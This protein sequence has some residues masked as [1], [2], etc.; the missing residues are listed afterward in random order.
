VPIA[1]VLRDGWGNPIIFVPASGLKE[2]R[3][4]D[5]AGTYVIRSN[6][7]YPYGATPTLASVEA[8]LP[9]SA[10]PFFASAGPD[11][12]FQKGD[13]NVYSFQP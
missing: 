2:V 1:P 13:D 9:P 7:A 4:G 10:R 8:I 5:G 12:D 6:K 11:G 3:L